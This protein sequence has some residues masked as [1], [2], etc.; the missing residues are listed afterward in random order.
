[1]VTVAST[2]QP[3]HRQRTGRL[4][5]PLAASVASIALGI[6]FVAYL[7][8]PRWPSPP[9]ALDA[10]ALPITIGGTLFN[11]P[12]A[13]IRVAVQRRPGAQERIDLAFLWPSLL[14]DP[15]N[16]QANSLG[17]ASNPL[18][19]I[20]VT[21]ANAD[22]G[23]APEERV[24]VIYPRYLGK[25][26]NTGPDG[27]LLLGFRAETPYQGE[28]LLYD[29][30]TPQRFVA[31]CTRTQGPAR[32]TCLSERRVGSADVTF[33]FLRDWLDQ[34]RDVASGTERLLASLRPAGG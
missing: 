19:R 15:A 32:G 11:V 30:G 26:P 7:L 12:P 29:G 9:L 34:W 25:T 24:K 16:K 6:A 14:P 28:D 10:P 23:L 8:W 21:I 22:S 13:A 2:R 31:R 5:L 4:V 17:G 20:F 1:M 18:D 27:L 3:S 33:R